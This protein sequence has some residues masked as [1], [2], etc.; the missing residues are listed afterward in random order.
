MRP[1]ILYIQHR[2]SILSSTLHRLEQIGFAAMGVQSVPSALDLMRVALPDCI[3]LALD[4]PQ[5]ELQHFLAEYANM[6][7][8]PLCAMRTDDNSQSYMNER[9]YS[10]YFHSIID[11]TTDSDELKRHFSEFTSNRR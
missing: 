11:T 2:H 7:P 9:K 8:V 3:L 6:R 1:R 4:C 5:C 10:A